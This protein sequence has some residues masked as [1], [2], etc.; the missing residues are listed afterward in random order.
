MCVIQPKS[1]K[2]V[3][4]VGRKGANFAKLISWKKILPLLLAWRLPFRPRRRPRFES[5]PSGG[6]SSTWRSTRCRS[7]ARRRTVG[8]GRSSG[9]RSEDGGSPAKR[10]ASQ[11]EDRLK[12][13]FMNISSFV[14]NICSIKIILLHK[15]DFDVV[16]KI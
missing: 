8:R 12:N 2:K 5:P 1:M 16:I 11:G 14:R 15:S 13:K 7:G 4:F 6:A 9:G 10:G 3:S